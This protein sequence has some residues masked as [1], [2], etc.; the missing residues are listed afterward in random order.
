VVGGARLF[1]VAK[2]RDRELERLERPP[3]CVGGLPVLSLY[4]L[5][6]FEIGR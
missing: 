2:L 5:I 6:W 1:L 3:D 4:Y